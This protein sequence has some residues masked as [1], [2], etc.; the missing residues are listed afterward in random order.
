MNTLKE[1]LAARK[2]ESDKKPSCHKFTL[3]NNGA[4]HV[5][6]WP[7]P[8]TRI[9]FP[10]GQ[11]CHHTLAPNP[12]DQAAPEKL[13][14]A[15]HTADVVIV[16]ARLTPLVEHVL[17]NALMSVTALDARYCETLGD[18][19]WVSKITVKFFGKQQA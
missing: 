6:F 14:L 1:Q 10:V 11:L 3:T 18:E 15:F 5:E 7:D 12:G 9:G 2:T 17:K 16:G 13:T 19:P 8:H 4:T